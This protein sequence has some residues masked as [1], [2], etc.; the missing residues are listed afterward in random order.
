MHLPAPHSCICLSS[1]NL[2]AVLWVSEPCLCVITR[3]RDAEMPT[4]WGFPASTC[5][6]CAPRTSFKARAGNWCRKAFSQQSVCSLGLDLVSFRASGKGRG[7][8]CPPSG[9]RGVHP[10][11]EDG[12]QQEVK[13]LTVD[14]TSL[15]PSPAFP[16]KGQELAASSSEEGVGGTRRELVPLQSHLLHIQFH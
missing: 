8:C 4:S 2:Q 16:G 6:I 12:C 3:C 1:T 14:S 7:L 9:S 11:W 5:K 13:E 15:A 10:C